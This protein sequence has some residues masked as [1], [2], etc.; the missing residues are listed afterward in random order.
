VVPGDL[1]TT[2][3]SARL[4]ERTWAA[5]RATVLRRT[6][7]AALVL[8]LVAAVGRGWIALKIHVPVVMTDELIY[9]EL[10]ESFGRTGHFLVRGES[11]GLFSLYPVLIAPFWRAGSIAT[12]YDLSKLLNVVAM[13]AASLLVFAWARKLVAPRYAVAVLALSL[14]MPTFIYTSEV[15]SES[16]AL[17]AYVLA[18]FGIW[19][20]LVYGPTVARQAGVLAAVALTTAIRAQGVVLVLIWA[21]SI[22]LCGALT[23]DGVPRWRAALRSFRPYWPS[24]VALVVAAGA[25]LLATAARGK[26]ALGFYDPVASAPYSIGR[27]AVWFVYHL[28]ELSIAT[29]LLPAAALLLLL[30]RAY[31]RGVEPAVAA[32]LAVTAASVLWLAAAAGTWASWHGDGIRERYDFY[33]VPLVLL[34]FGVFLQG[35][36]FRRRWA[37]IAGLLAC[38]A[39][40]A[41]PLPRLL[42]YGVLAKAPSLDGLRWLAD[43]SGELVRPVSAVFAVVAFGVLL[44]RRPGVIALGFVGILLLLNSLAATALAHDLSYRILATSHASSWVDDRIGRDGDAGVVWTG[45]VDPNWVWQIEFW[46]SSVRR[47]YFRDQRD[48]GTLPT[49]RLTID[50]RSSELRGDGRPLPVEALVADRSFTVDGPLRATLPNGLVLVGVSPNTTAGAIVGGVYGDGW[51][52]PALTYTRRN[53]H[54]ITE[55]GFRFRSGPNA[56]PQTATASQAGRVVARQ[57]FAPGET[58][59]VRAPLDASRGTCTLRVRVSPT[60][61]PAERVSGSPDTRPLGLIYEETTRLP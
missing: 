33:A 23:A 37:F 52:G 12:S 4:A 19:G 56:P 54:G 35:A 61:I 39:P 14:L 48:P 11:I 60:W 10:A 36:V 31:R 53:C 9:R 24:A 25:F 49:Q 51:T 5:A 28:A 42:S 47:V 3:S 6:W 27:L 57:R 13:T 2:T 45:N 21:T 41:L 43:Q 44:L 15:M 18:A 30:G 22:A 59:L 40:L 1:L 7:V 46:N 32:L 29:G 16:V 8:A 58:S 50:P 55:L 38:L 26:S 20:S 17:A 34:V